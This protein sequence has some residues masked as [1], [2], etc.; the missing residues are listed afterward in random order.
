MRQWARMATGSLA[1]AWLTAL[2][3][4]LVCGRLPATVR[5]CDVSDRELAAAVQS[6][7]RLPLTWSAGQRRPPL[8]PLQGQYFERGGQLV[9]VGAALIPG[10]VEVPAFQAT[11]AFEQLAYDVYGRLGGPLL[12]FMRRQSPDRFPAAARFALSCGITQAGHDEPQGL[13]VLWDGGISVC[14]PDIA[15]PLFPG[16]SRGQI[17]AS[18]A[19]H[20]LGVAVEGSRVAVRLDDDLVFDFHAPQPPSG[21]LAIEALEGAAT[22]R[23]IEVKSLPTR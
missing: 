18:A 6:P 8:I 13:H 14:A 12:P 16:R 10:A 2:A 23:M 17:A 4:A 19:S 1:V 20:R 22:V 7:A 21:C 3:L 11:V 9:L 15:T 5:D